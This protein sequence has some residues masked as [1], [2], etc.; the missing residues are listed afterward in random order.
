MKKNIFT[1]L[2]L[3]LALTA[4]AV[5]AAPYGI[6]ALL[7]DGTET[8]IY[9]HGDEYYNYVTDAQGNWLEQNA[10]GRYDFVPAKSIDE[11]E[12]LHQQG[13]NRLPAAYEATGT[14]RNLAPRGLCILV[15]FKNKKFVT[16]TA[17]I[18]SMLNGR[19]Y[20]RFRDGSSYPYAKGSTRQYFIDQSHGL[21]HPDFDVVGPV[22]LDYNYIYYGEGKGDARARNMIVE[23]VQKSHD[24]LGVNFSVYDNDG[25]NKVDFVYVL[26]AGYG[27][28][29]SPDANTVWPHSSDLSLYFDIVLDGKQVA[30]Y[31]CSNEIKYNYGQNEQHTGIGTFTHEFSHVLGLPDFYSTNSNTTHKTLG[32]WDIMD[33]GPYNNDGNTPP[34]YSGYEKW[35]MDWATP[36]VVTADGQYTLE[37][38]ATTNEFLLVS[39]TRTSNLDGLNPEPKKFWLL[40]NRQ[41]NSSSWENYIPG[42]G[43]L[44]VRVQYNRNKWYMN[45]VN[46]DPKD[47]GVNIIEADGKAPAMGEQGYNGKADDAFP[48][49]QKKYTSYNAGTFRLNNIKIWNSG[50]AQFDLAF[51][52]AGIEDVLTEGETIEA[53]Y[54]ILGKQLPTTDLSTL[55]NGVYV[56]R[57]TSGTKKVMIP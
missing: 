46:N 48:G 41:R 45:Q 25:D 37:A 20:Q 18:D 27:A 32:D 47:M 17:E 22:E 40:E 10:N 42:D 43:L 13:M 7:E 9:L 35:F 28:A 51:R 31:A 55:A 21:Y 16:E 52:G 5:P 23:A 12:A 24:S 57:T 2:S 30:T 54:D 11:I 3:L 26:Y 39:S 34:S 49:V 50:K 8:T 53:I 33:S 19:N 44:L 36:T 56:I 1:L 15:N 14:S 38:F 29:D 4:S 6:R